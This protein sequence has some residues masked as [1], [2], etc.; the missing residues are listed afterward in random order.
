MQSRQPRKEGVS[1]AALQTTLILDRC[2]AIETR[3]GDI[4]RHFAELCQHQPELEILWKKTAHEE[5]HHALQFKMLSRLKGEGIAGVNLDVACVTGALNKVEDLFRRIKASRISAVDMLRVAIRL[6]TN[7][8][9]YHSNSVVAC[10]EPEL[11]QLLD[12]MMNFDLDHVEMLQKALDKLMAGME[13][14]K[15]LE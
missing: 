10:E 7:L 2:A 14:G 13:E 11:K 12:S 5:D 3:C 15:E 1:P 8:S 6:E 9:R 4:Y